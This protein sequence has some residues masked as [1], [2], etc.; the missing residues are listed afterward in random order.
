ME[1]ERYWKLFSKTGKVEDYLKFVQSKNR[2][3]EV[4]VGEIFSG[5]AGNKGKEYR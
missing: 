2:F 5:S 4:K 1:Q 3:S